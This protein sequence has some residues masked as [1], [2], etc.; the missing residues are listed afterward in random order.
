MSENQERHR[1][2]D[3][4][5]VEEGAPKQALSGGGS[6]TQAGSAEGGSAYGD[7]REDAAREAPDREAPEGETPEGGLKADAAEETAAPVAPPPEDKTFASPDGQEG[8]NQAAGESIVNTGEPRPAKN[9][10]GVEGRPGDD[11]DASTG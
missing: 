11:V 1:K 6:E 8:P 5:S 7:D 2:P 4:P 3:T 9:R 10:E